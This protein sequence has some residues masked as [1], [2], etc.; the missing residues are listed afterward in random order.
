MRCYGFSWFLIGIHLS[1]RYFQFSSY[2]MFLSFFKFNIWFFAKPSQPMF[3]QCFWGSLTFVC[4][5]QWLPN[6]SPA[7]QC[8]RC[9]AQG[10][11]NQNFLMEEIFFQDPTSRI[12]NGDRRKVVMEENFVWPTTKNISI[13]IFRSNSAVSLD[14]LVNLIRVT[15]WTSWKIGE[16]GKWKTIQVEEEEGDYWSFWII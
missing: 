14:T 6:F 1:S 16:A 5:F 8:L 11:Q 13:F 12:Q 4:D 7:M 10:Y 15:N 3:L 2:I 9:T